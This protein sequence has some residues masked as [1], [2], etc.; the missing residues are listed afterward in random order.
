MYQQG[1]VFTPYPHEHCPN[2]GAGLEQLLR[3]YA[4]TTTY[5]QRLHIVDGMLDLDYEKEVSF[6]PAGDITW[7]CEACQSQFSYD[8]AVDWVV[9]E[10]SEQ[11]GEP[12]D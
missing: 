3:Y 6:E 5:E 4:Y 1:W 2:C 9:D 7:V 8:I 11:K 10:T 12:H